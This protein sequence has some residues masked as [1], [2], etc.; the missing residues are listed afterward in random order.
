MM[1]MALAI[2]VSAQK[3]YRPYHYYNQPRVYVSMGAF[4]PYPYYGYYNPFWPYPGLYTPPYVNRP[5]KLEMEIQD[6][7]ND[8]KD[9]IQSAR[10]N[11]ELSHSEKK[12][13]IHQLK[14]ERDQ[15]IED[16]RNNYYKEK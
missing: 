3:Y 2:T 15:A 5:S 13:I 6:I 16:A 10:N 12:E 1:S 9:R 14:A 7:K 4:A 8:Y 11:K